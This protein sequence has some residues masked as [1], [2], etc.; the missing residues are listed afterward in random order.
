M[1]LYVGLDVSLRTISVCIVEAK[2]KVVWEGKVLCEGPALIA[3]LAPYRKKIKRIGIEAG[4]LSEWLFGILT[5]CHFNAVCIEARRAH[6]FLSSRP[7]KTDRND[8]HGIADMMRLGHFK[9]VH[10]KSRASQLLRTMLAARKTF[11]DHMLE[12]EQAI[13]GFLKVYGLKLGQ[14]HRYNFSAKVR[15]LVADTPELSAAIAPLLD[16]R[17][18]MRQ[19]KKEIDRELEKR[20]RQDAVCRR[21][22]TIPGVGPII[23]AARP[24]RRY[25]VRVSSASPWTDLRGEGEM[26]CLR[27]PESLALPRCKTRR[28]RKALALRPCKQCRVAK[29]DAEEAPEAAEGAGP[30]LRIRPVAPDSQVGRGGQSS[31]FYRV[32]ACG[33]R[34]LS[35]PTRSRQAFLSCADQQNAAV[36]AL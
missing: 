34:I 11:V 24:E 25:G 16:A 15:A 26:R 13:R 8:A 7:N 14:V 6:R 22:M 18:M 19:K 30:S 2:G 17:D 4:P 33:K 21:L 20:A 32:E 31:L 9:A 28:E 36:G 29:V 5:E 12:I 3:A 27:C 35:V 23:S 10:V 1:A